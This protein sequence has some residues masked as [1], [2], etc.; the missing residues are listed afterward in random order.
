MR[1]C[2]NRFYV[3]LIADHELA[4]ARFPPQALPPKLVRSKLDNDE[5]GRKQF[6]WQAAEFTLWTMLPTGKAYKSW[7]IVRFPTD[8]P[9]QAERVKVVTEYL[10]EDSTI[11]AFKMLALKPGYVYEVQWLYK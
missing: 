6:R 9:Q 11:L 1:C 4:K 10:A 3:T 8:E 5:T 2:D 7:R